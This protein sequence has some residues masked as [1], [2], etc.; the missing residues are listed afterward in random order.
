M[1]DRAADAVGCR[2]D[3]VLH[4]GE[5]EHQQPDEAKRPGAAEGVVFAFLIFSRKDEEDVAEIPARLG[6]N[7]NYEC[8]KSSNVCRF[9]L[10]P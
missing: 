1:R 2:Q 10:S 6:R 9:A 3:G 5:E 8:G 4:A 7:F